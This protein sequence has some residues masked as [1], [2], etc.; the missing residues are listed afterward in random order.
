MKKIFHF[1]VFSALLFLIFIHQTPPAY[2]DGLSLIAR[3]V[4]RTLFSVFELPRT[5]L[6]TALV[7]PPFGLLLGTLEG[8]IRATA[9]T[10]IGAV[11]IARGAAPYAKYAI[12]F[13]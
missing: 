11:D 3:G 7:A 12:F 9:G 1:T 10:L 6:S 13:V 8:T 5:M 4:A 2:A